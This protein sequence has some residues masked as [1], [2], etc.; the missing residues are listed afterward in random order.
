[1]SVVLSHRILIVLSLRRSLYSWKS[2]KSIGKFPLI[3]D[4]ILQDVRKLDRSVLINT[5]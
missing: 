2:P 4:G 5:F 3:D 1:M